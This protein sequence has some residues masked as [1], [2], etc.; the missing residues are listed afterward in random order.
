MQGSFYG[1]RRSAQW[2]TQLLPFSKESFPIMHLNLADAE[3]EVK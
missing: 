3:E 2:W 1:S